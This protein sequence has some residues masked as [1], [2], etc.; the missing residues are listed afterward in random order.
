MSEMYP[1]RFSPILRRYLWGG[2]RLES[3]LG[4][5]LG[6]EDD[7]AESWEIVDHGQDQSIVVHGALF[8]QTLGHLVRT[9]GEELL[10]RHHPQPQF[11]LLFKFLD[12]HKTLSVQVHPDDAGAARLDP[13]DLGKTEAWVIV[14]AEPGSLIYA[15]LKRGF[16][17]AALSREVARGTTELC[18]HRIE[19]QAGQCIFIPARTVHALGSGLVVAEIQQASDTTFR[20][21]D[22]NRVGADGNPRVLHID[23]SLETIDYAQGPVAPQEILPTNHPDKHLLVACDKF[24]LYRWQTKTPQTI[25]LGN[26]CRILAMIAGCARIAGDPSGEEFVK[27]DTALLPACLGSTTITPLSE[28]TFLEIHLPLDGTGG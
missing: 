21:Y 6:P 2:R 9:C 16:D 15:G 4:K 27:G 18:L 23:Q 26:H 22:W 24:V 5:Q 3:E 8:G 12:A 28:V 10:G 25:S 1:L 14:S 20:L 13:P 7:Y 11:P 19:A 17:R